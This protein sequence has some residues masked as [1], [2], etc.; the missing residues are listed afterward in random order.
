MNI[1][2][3]SVILWAPIAAAPVCMLGCAGPAASEVASDALMA[4]CSGS[5]SGA[6]DAAAGPQVS[7]IA[8]VRTKNGG[9]GATSA[10]FDAPQASGDL[11]VA[12]IGWGDDTTTVTGIT[13]TNGNPYTIAA[14]MATE[15]GS[16]SPPLREAIYYAKNIVGG[17]NTL[18]AHFDSAP[19][20]P[21]LRLLEYRGIDPS[22]PFDVTSSASGTG[23]GT[24]VS[25]GSARTRAPNELIVGAGID[26][27]RL[28]RS[29]G[30]LHEKGR[31]LGRKPRQGRS[32]ERRWRV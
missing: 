13:D 28:H 14:P 24:T 10:K 15:T 8:W 1:I 18:T 32:R 16:V 4:F 26:D 20:Y 23:A 17:A 5:D 21:D 12:I 31:H 30:L 19:A 2:K 7:T 3:V 27:R 25:S 22:A 6:G 11:N 29:R 9:S